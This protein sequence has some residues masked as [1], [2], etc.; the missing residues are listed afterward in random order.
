[1][2]ATLGNGGIDGDFRHIP[3][4]SEVVVPFRVLGELAALLLHGIGGLYG[5]KPV[6]TDS[7]H[8][9]GV[10]GKHGDGADILEHVLGRDRLGANPAAG[11]G[12]VGWNLGTQVVADHNHVEQFG[13]RVDPIG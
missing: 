3:K 9:L 6:F 2:G 8:G 7:T 5:P 13:L 4:H 10:A 1:M 11:E 12:D